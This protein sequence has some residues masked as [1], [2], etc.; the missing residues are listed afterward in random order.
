MRRIVASGVHAGLVALLVSVA[1]CD[2][3]GVDEGVPKDTTPVVPLDTI[4]ANMDAQRPTHR[5]QEG[6]VEVGSAHEAMK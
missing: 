6:R 1:G 5:G 4:K 3:G 2:G